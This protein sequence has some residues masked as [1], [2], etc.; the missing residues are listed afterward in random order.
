MVEAMVEMVGLEETQGKETVGVNRDQRMTSG[1]TSGN[2]PLT[3]PHSR[4]DA[5]TSGSPWQVGPVGMEEK[6]GK[7][8]KVEMVVQEVMAQQPWRLL[9][10]SAALRGHIGPCCGSS[11]CNPVLPKTHPKSSSPSN[12]PFHHRSH[13]RRSRPRGLA[14]FRKLRCPR[15]L[16]GR[17]GRHS[18]LPRLQL[19]LAP[20]TR[21]LSAHFHC[22]LVHRHSQSV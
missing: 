11:G 2:P 1:S 3:S 10:M 22:C 18:C 8:E 20:W 5:G 14:S 21:P 15:H 7:E 13:S 6:E 16:S 12:N 17:A 19:T 4:P 9:G